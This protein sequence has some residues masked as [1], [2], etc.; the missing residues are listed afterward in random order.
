MNKDKKKLFE[1]LEKICKVKL[2][3]ESMHNVDNIINYL[4]KNLVLN[5]DLDE[6]IND[7]DE[8]EFDFNVNNEDFSGKISMTVYVEC[9][10]DEESEY[11]SGYSDCFVNDI[12][13]SNLEIKNNSGNIIDYPDDFLSKLE[14]QI[15]INIK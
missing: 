14:K 7:I 3:K 9:D 2:I 4:L 13:I 8:Y 1:A 11:A 15:E 6:G 12:S 10:N 5:L